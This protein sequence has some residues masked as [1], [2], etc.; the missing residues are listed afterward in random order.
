MS[1]LI[2]RIKLEDFSS[3]ILKANWSTILQRQLSLV[4]AAQ[5][6]RDYHSFQDQA[7]CELYESRHA[8]MNKEVFLAT[9]FYAFLERQMKRWHGLVGM[10][11]MAWWLDQVVFV[12]F[13]NLTDSMKH[14]YLPLTDSVA[15]GM[16]QHMGAYRPKSL[17][18]ISLNKVP[19]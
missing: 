9:S 7:L 18:R 14:R 3:L 12:A 11:I 16:R 6:S 8:G 10:V 1:W 19:S 17:Q 4:P 2:F 13:S 5:C 15:E